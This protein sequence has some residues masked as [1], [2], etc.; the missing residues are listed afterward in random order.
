MALR[1]RSSRRWLSIREHGTGLVERKPTPFADRWHRVQKAEK[2]RH[3]MTIMQANH[4]TRSHLRENSPDLPEPGP[5]DVLDLS[6]MSRISRRCSRLLSQMS[7]LSL[8]TPNQFRSARER[9]PH[10]TEHVTF[11]GT[12]WAVTFLGTV[13]SCIEFLEVFNFEQK[14]QLRS[15]Y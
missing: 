4:H 5:S 7:P 12:F 10:G 15:F 2:G 6:Q 14:S 13:F 11:L 3:A 9:N 8:P 1:C